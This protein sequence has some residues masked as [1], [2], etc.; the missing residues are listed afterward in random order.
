[1]RIINKGREDA[2]RVQMAAWA[3]SVLVVAG[4]VALSVGNS[5]VFA[6]EPDAATKAYAQRVAITVCGTCHGSRGNS[7]HPKFPR[8]AGQNVH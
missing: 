1:M 3:R 8:L 6:D 4:T 7:T 2:G 5:A